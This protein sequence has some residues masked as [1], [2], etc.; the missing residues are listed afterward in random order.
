MA[1]SGSLALA[2]GLVMIGIEPTLTLVWAGIA[3]VAF[4]MLFP[5]AITL[6]L[7][8]AADSHDALRLTAGTLGLGYLVS[9]AGSSLSGGLRDLSGSFQPVFLVLAAIG[10]LPIL[11]ALALRRRPPAAAGGGGTEISTIPGFS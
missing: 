1:I 3:G 10:L 6:P 8:Y 11:A 2:A 4:G 5:I 9:S 7:D